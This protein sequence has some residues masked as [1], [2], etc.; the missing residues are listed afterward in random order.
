MDFP[1]GDLLSITYIILLASAQTCQLFKNDLMAICK[2]SKE[3]KYDFIARIRF[4]EHFKRSSIEK[5][6]N[7]KKI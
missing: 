2:K 7:L 5:E 1:I 4:A 6:G 3:T